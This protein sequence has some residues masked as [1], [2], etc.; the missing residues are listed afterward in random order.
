MLTGKK[1]DKLCYHAEQCGTRGVYNQS[2]VVCRNTGQLIPLPLHLL[3]D[4]DGHGQF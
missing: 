1:A 4:T 2:R 3:P